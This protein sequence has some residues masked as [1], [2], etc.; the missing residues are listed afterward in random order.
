MGLSVVTPTLGSIMRKIQALTV[1]HFIF[2]VIYSLGTVS[3]EIETAS[4]FGLLAIIVGLSLSLTT[5]LMW[6]AVSRE[7]PLLFSF[8]PTLSLGKR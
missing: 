8:F 1:A 5:F 3:V 2:G 6:T 7:F 4:L